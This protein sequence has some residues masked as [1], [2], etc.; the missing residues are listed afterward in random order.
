[1]HCL[2]RVGRSAKQ[3]IA[4]RGGA[5]L[6]AQETSNRCWSIDALAQDSSALK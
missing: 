6:N 5:F 2:K 4:Q 1:M 3:V